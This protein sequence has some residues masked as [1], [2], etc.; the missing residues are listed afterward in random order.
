MYRMTI[1]ENQ[2][3]ILWGIIMDQKKKR[4]F[5]LSIGLNV[6]FVLFLVWGL[7]K[8]ND[9]TELQ[10]FDAEAK[11]R[12]LE[13]AIVYQVENDWSQPAVV[14]SSLEAAVQEM[15]HSANLVTLSNKERETFTLLFA[16]LSSYQKDSYESLDNYIEFSEEDKR[17]FERLG[18]SLLIV[19][20]RDMAEKV[21]DSEGKLSKATIISRAKKLLE[22]LRS[23]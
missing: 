2:E 22:S 13:D 12:Q 21:I 10:L 8:I 15:N 7:F 3:I 14:G 11:L 4:L 6:L 20:Y 23:S 9:Y 1:L 18:E 5:Y 17:K 19:G 16:I